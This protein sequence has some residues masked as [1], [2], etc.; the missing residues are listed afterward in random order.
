MT[1]HRAAPSN[2]RRIEDDRTTM[3]QPIAGRLPAAPYVFATVTQSP[4]G[5]SRM[6]RTT[7]GEG[8]P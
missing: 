3:N 7:S 8:T 5:R 6:G 4:H 2:R 1:T